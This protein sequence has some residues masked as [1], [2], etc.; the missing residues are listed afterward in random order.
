MDGRK[1]NRLYTAARGVHSTT[2]ECDQIAGTI[3]WL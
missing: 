3:P 2:T 1:G